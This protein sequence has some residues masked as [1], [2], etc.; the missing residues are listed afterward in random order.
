MLMSMQQGCGRLAGKTAIVTGAGRGIGRGTAL[1]FAR[2]GA[3]VV[4]MARTESQIE[5]TARD[6]RALGRRSL[7]VVGDVS[8]SADCDRLVQSALDFLGHVDILIN[9]AG[10]GPQ[11]KITE[12]SEEDWDQCLAA[13]VKSVYMLSKRILPHMIGR[14]HG[15]IINVA[16]TRAFG[17]RPNA[18]P[19]CV[20]KAGVVMLTKCIALDYM[21]EGIRCNAIAPG[22]IEVERTL[23]MKEAV[24]H[25]E[26]AEEILR[27]IPEAN[28]PSW[29]AKIEDLRKLPDDQLDKA[30][31]G[32]GPLHKR[33]R[34]EDCANTIVFLA[35]DE[36]PFV[37]GETILVDGG[38]S[39][40]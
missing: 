13:N 21:H 37:N 17:A 19:Y 22:A 24:R 10:G 18:A 16:S 8:K 3:D 15:N 12:L 9:N 34:V 7:A 29:M 1:A 28:R 36:A 2:E 4:V 26:R 11:N 32:S 20:A 14:H 35:S 23:W 30:L 31:S 39:V 6:V 38:T 25:P 33:G 27:Q 40:R 5:K